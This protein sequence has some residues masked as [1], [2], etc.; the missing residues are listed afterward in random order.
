MAVQQKHGE[1]NG[2][3]GFDNDFTTDQS[4]RFT[5]VANSAVKRRVKKREI[6]APFIQS[7][8]QTVLKTVVRPKGNNPNRAR[9]VVWIII[10][11]LVSLWLMYMAG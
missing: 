11:G 5:E 3:V 2:R 8:K 7:A 1:K 9:Q 10:I 4:Q 6:E